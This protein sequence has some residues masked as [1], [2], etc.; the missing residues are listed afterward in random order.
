MSSPFTAL[1]GSLPTAFSFTLTLGSTR[2]CSIP[3]PLRFNLPRQPRGHALHRR[4]GKTQPSVQNRC[5][6]DLR[7]G[8]QTSLIHRPRIWSATLR[9]QSENDPLGEAGSEWGAMR[10]G[11]SRPRSRWLSISSTRATLWRLKETSKRTTLRMISPN[12]RRPM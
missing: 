11:S 7:L 12:K 5:L 1:R 8:N 10:A 4:H 6:E 2:T 3:L 9:S